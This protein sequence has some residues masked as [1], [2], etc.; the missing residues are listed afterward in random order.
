MPARATQSRSVRINS[1]EASTVIRQVNSKKVGT[2]SIRARRRAKSP[3]MN[4]AALLGQ[5]P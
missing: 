3:H 4:T 2:H 5:W 1:A